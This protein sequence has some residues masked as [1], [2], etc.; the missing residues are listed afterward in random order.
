[1]LLANKESL[2]RSGD[3][4][5]VW[6]AHGATTLK[7]GQAVYMKGLYAFDCREHKYQLLQE[8]GYD[9]GGQASSIP[10]EQGFQNVVPDSMQQAIE[11][12][13]CKPT[14]GWWTPV[15]RVP[16]TLEKRIQAANE[17]FFD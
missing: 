7:P 3:S 11:Q 2:V 12:F 5:R 1:M 15:V 10:V 6:V 13:A 8:V 16:E 17:G 4:A 14:N 9:R